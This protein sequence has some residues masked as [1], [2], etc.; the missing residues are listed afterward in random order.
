MPRTQAKL[1]AGE[2]RRIIAD[3]PN[4]APVLLETVNLASNIKYTRQIPCRSAVVIDSYVYLGEL[5]DND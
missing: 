2:L 4:D 1:T 5:D 3:A